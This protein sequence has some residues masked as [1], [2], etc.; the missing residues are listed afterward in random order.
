MFYMCKKLFSILSISICI[1][2]YIPI[3][4]DDKVSLFVGDKP[5]K[6]QFND[7][8]NNK[9][10]KP[11][12]KNDYSL[13]NF[14]I[15]DDSEDI[16]IEKSDDFGNFKLCYNKLNIENIKIKLGIN[17]DD[18][19]ILLD[20][21]RFL[22]DKEDESSSQG[23]IAILLQNNDYK[24]IEISIW[25][26]NRNST[27][28]K[29]EFRLC[30]NEFFSV[31]KIDLKDLDF[32]MNEIKPVPPAAKPVVPVIKPPVTTPAKP[33]VPVIKPPVKPVTTPVINPEVKPVV[34]PVIQPE[35]PPV[36]QPVKPVIK[37][38]QPVIHTEVKP[39]K[40]IDPGVS[41]KGNSKNNNSCSCKK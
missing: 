26:D 24:I 28:N 9:G 1:I 3:Y 12:L 36:I 20:K 29:S 35:V 34:P 32:K 30:R 5:F 4:S 31:Y 37:P 2:F 16:E 18:F 40:N 13:L 17:G 25:D 15:E 10:L 33:V 7:K 39:V 23:L 19:I 14:V 41:D 22:F 38:V 21:V 8:K 27:I 11:I 6:E